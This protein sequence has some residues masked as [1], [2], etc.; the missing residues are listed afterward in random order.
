MT[1]KVDSIKF[2]CRLETNAMYESKRLSGVASGA[3]YFI[4]WSRRY[5]DIV[6]YKAALFPWH[7]F[8]FI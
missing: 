2:F 5:Y 8:A 7:G 3:V 6:E 4:L 1:I